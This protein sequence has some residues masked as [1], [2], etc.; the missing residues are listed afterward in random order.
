MM[1]AKNLVLTFAIATL[2][3]APT[4]AL[5]A[6]P[7]RIDLPAARMGTVSFPHAVHQQRTASCEVCHHKGV[8]AG[9]CTSCHEVEKSPPQG[10][11]LFHKICRSCHE[12]EGGP[13]QCRGCHS[14]S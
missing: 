14:R 7:E 5:P 6:G 4:T 13:L 11:D 2:A 9:A 10:R 12:R 1:T 8:E 3:S